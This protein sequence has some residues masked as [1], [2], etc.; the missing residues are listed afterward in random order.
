VHVCG[1][2]CVEVVESLMSFSVNFVNLAGFIHVGLIHFE[3]HT[4]LFLLL[5]SKPGGLG[6]SIDD[7]GWAHIA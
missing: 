5:M 2:V 6:W 3:T 7:R 1:C 4:D